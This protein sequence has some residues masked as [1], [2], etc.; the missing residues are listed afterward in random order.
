MIAFR[1][2]A[3]KARE[4][5]ATARRTGPDESGHWVLTLILRKLR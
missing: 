3:A 2:E 4:L 5:A 1:K